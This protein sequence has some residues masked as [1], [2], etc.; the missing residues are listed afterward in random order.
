MRASDDDRQQVVNR[1][2]TPGPCGWPAPTAP[3]CWLFPRLW[4]T[5][6]AAAGMPRHSHP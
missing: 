1:L 3:R 2:S 6:G 4:C 5:T